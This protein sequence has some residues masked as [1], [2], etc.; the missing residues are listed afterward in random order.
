MVY[1]IDEIKCDVTTDTKLLPFLAR[2]PRKGKATPV[3]EFEHRRT[4]S[5]DK[6]WSSR[7]TIFF[8]FLANEALFIF[9][10][11]MLIYFY[12]SYVRCM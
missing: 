3:R 2:F 9:I 4:V 12:Y 5:K 11:P 6:E 1:I 10:I 7:S 8:K